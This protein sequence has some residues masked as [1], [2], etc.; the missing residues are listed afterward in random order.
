[1][2]KLIVAGN[3][4]SYVSDAAQAKTLASALKRTAR[5]TAGI[6][7]IILP[8]ASLLAVV[9]AAA[10]KTMIAVGAQTVSPFGR[11]AYTGYVSAEAVKNAG[12]SWALIGHSERRAQVIDGL[13]AAGESEDIIAAEVA[14]AHGAGL[15]VMLCVGELERDPSGAHFAT[16]ARQ[17][18]SA[19]AHF[20]KSGAKLVIA[21][22][23]VW[24][25]GKSAA[26]ACKPAD[27]E[28]M[29]IF[30]RRT[31]TE[32]FDRAAA[33]KIPILYG[34]SVDA[35]NARELLVQGGVSGFLVGRAS[36][37]AKSFIELLK[38]C[39]S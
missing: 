9:A 3:W 13:Q 20:P 34:G 38:V 11:G 10:A 28:E 25:I 33:T 31:L 5:D 6:D 24:A 26:E 14:A 27:L 7:I 35:T 8:P 22:E 29:S 36:T 23:P 32:L 2:K 1:V 30:I 17:L 4:K 39:R 18:S 16:I 21:Y 37:D 15:R 12:A 19:L